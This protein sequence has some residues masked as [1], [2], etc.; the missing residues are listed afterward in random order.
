MADSRKN[1]KKLCFVFEKETKDAIAE[2][3]YPIAVIA[4]VVEC[5]RHF[6]L[7]RGLSVNSWLR[8]DCWSL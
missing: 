3:R 5:Y 2:K 7:H 8:F 1:E 6:R 4:M